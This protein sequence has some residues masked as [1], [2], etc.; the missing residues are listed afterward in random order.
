MAGGTQSVSRREAMKT[1]LKASAYAAPIVLSAVVPP[2]VAAATPPPRTVTFVP[3]PGSP[4]PV[5]TAPTAIVIADFNG[6]GAQDLAVTNGMSNNM[7]VLLGNGTGTF[8]PALG[9]PVVVGNAPVGIVAGDFNGDRKTDVAIVN[10]NDNTVSVLLGN[11][12]G[13]FTPAAGSPITVGN[14]PVALAVGDFNRDGKLDLAVVNQNSGNVSVLL[15]NGNGTFTPAAGS[16]IPVGNSVDIAVGDFNGDGKPDLAIVTPGLGVTILLG[17]G[18]GGFSLAPGSPFAVGTTPLKIA[19]GDFNGDGRLDLAV[20]DNSFN[21]VNVLLGSGNGTFTP[22]PGSPITVGTSP[23]ALAVADFN[24]DGNL[25][26]A[27]ANASSISPTTLPGNVMVLLG[28][29]NGTFTPN[30]GAPFT[31]G[32][33]PDAIAV[34]DFNG[35]GKP[36]L[37]VANFGSNNMSVLLQ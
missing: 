27:V 32:V 26:L 19:V 15:G 24:G 25:D 16:P 30:T 22:A 31:V 21:K 8:A 14:A 37:A 33:E 23:A 7:S 9:S 6:D 4:F 34:G 10:S 5:G 11:G 18:S 3:A 28:N 36:D 2:A 1:A 13:T 20:T 17:N 29:G 12:N 35:N